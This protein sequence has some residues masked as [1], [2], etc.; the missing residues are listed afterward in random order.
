MVEHRRQ[1]YA[2]PNG[3]AY[4]KY[5]RQAEVCVPWRSHRCGVY[6]SGFI[7]ASRCGSNRVANAPE[8]QRSVCW[9]GRLYVSSHGPPSTRRMSREQVNGGC[10]GSPRPA[11]GEA[12][13]RM[14]KMRECHRTVA[15]SGKAAACSRRPRESCCAAAGVLARCAGARRGRRR[16]CACARR[17]ASLKVRIQAG[18]AVWQRGR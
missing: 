1:R 13:N 7:F 17:S 3:R 2:V 9:Q 8:H 15:R 4:A 10:P 11:S 12:M 18:V 6:G 16:A 5:R 14:R